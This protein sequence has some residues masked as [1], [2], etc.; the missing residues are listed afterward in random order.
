MAIATNS[1]S[2]YSFFPRK[3]FFAAHSACIILRDW[4]A[5]ALLLLSCSSSSLLSKRDSPTDC[6]DHSS[7]SGTPLLFYAAKIG[8][9]EIALLNPPRHCEKVFFSMQ[10][11]L[12]GRIALLHPLHKG[13]KLSWSLILFS[14]ILIY[15]TT[16]L[17]PNTSRA[18]RL[19]FGV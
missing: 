11:P 5:C 7:R 18:S 13:V 3:L 15:C 16:M 2:S 19:H 10:G 17:K 14:L 1:I 9:I 8:T 6:V 4:C 12:R